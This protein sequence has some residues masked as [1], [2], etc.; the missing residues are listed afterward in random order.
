MTALACMT[1]AAP[2]AAQ[3]GVPAE[4]PLADHHIHIFSPDASAVLKAICKAVGPKRCPEEISKE[5]STGDDVVRALDAAG[6]RKGVLL[7]GAYFFASPAAAVPPDKLALE[8]RAENSF[9]VAQ[10]KAHCGRLVPIISV[11]PL[12]PGAIA[13]IDHWGKV[14]GAAG[15]KLHLG[16]SGFDFRDPAQVRKLA[17]VFA[18]A[19]R[20][21]LAIVIHLQTQLSSYG[22]EDAR[23]FLNRV[24]PSAPHVAIQIAHVGSGGGLDKGALSV[25]AVF[26]DAIHDKPTVTR[27]LVFDLAMVPDLFSNTRKLSAAATDDAALRSMMRGIGLERFV[28]GSDYTFGLDLRAYYRNQKASLALGEPEWRTIANN[29]APY[30]RHWAPC[31]HH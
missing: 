3:V 7:S 13:E 26:A 16:N 21:H 9:I 17:A 19:D 8:I 1:V 5:P 15:L 31:R 12:R 4:T 6:I 14:G 18:A 10:A 25:L 28:P 20:N 30:V 22:P 24:L 29:Q 23:I 11:N 2:L 27:H